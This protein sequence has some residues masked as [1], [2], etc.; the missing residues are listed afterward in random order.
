MTDTIGKIEITEDV[1]QIRV[2]AIARALSLQNGIEPIDSADGS[3]NHFMFYRNAT[4]ICVM[5]F[6]DEY[7]EGKQS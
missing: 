6:P 1:R 3:A 7:R 4:R 2:D 5:A